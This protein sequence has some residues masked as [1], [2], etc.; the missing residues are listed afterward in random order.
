M[1]DEIETLKEQLKQ[2]KNE[3]K[4]LEKENKLLKNKIKIIIIGINYFKNQ[5]E[6]LRKNNNISTQFEHLI[7][8]EKENS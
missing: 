7:N 6:D 5:I 4:S 8:M 2:S 1:L 3:V